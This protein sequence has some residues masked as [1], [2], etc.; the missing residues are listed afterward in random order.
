MEWPC[1]CEPVRT[2]AR[3]SVPQPTAHAFGPP[4]GPGSS[5]PLLVPSAFPQPEWPPLR[6]QDR[7]FSLGRSIRPRA[8]RAHFWTPVGVGLARPAPRPFRRAGRPRPAAARF[9][10]L[11]GYRRAAAGRPCGCGTGTFRRGGY[12]PPMGEG[13]RARR[14]QTL[15]ATRWRAF[16]QPSSRL[17]APPPARRPSFT[18]PPKPETAHRS[19]S[20]YPGPPAAPS[21]NRD[22]RSSPASG[23]TSP[24]AWAAPVA[25]PSRR[26]AAGGPPRRGG[27]APGPPPPGAPACESAF[28]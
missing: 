12:H 13:G 24:A 16:A 10:N 28:S 8:H 19:G 14:A 17:N 26:P 4:Q 27:A 23:R 11:N 20:R 9:P 5:G 18:S 22:S 7:D 3:Q 15:P 21:S 6:M 25:C 1:H 2:L